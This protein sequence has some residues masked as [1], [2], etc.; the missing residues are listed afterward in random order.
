MREYIESNAVR[1]KMARS[2]VEGD[3]YKKMNN[4]IYGA[5][6]HDRSKHLDAE[7]VM[8]GGSRLAELVKKPQFKTFIEFSD[9]TGLVIKRKQKILQTN[10][11]PIAFGILSV[12]KLILLRNYYN[13]LLPALQRTGAETIT[14]YSDTGA[15][16]TSR[17]T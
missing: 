17:F 13:I 2:K 14:C 3:L 8:G 4:V 6:L 5:Q 10:C 7:I 9:Q 11:T 1:R 16:K 15:S 12:S